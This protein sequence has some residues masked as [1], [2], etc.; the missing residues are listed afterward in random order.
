LSALHDLADAIGILPAYHDVH[1]TLRHTSDETRALLLGALGYDVADEAAA[2]RSLEGLRAAERARVIE[3]VAVTPV[4]GDAA[5]A[6]DVRLPVATAGAVRWQLEVVEEAGAVHRA[7]GELSR[8]APWQLTL[9]L[10]ELPLGYHS[11]RLALQGAGADAAAE[12]TRIVVPPSCVRV[13]ELLGERG[14]FGLVANLYSVRREADWGVGDLRSL[15]MLLD[16]AA[17]VGGSFVGVNPLH[18]LRNRD[19]DVSPYSPVSRLFRNPLYIDVPSVPEWATTPSARATLDLPQHQALLEELREADRIDYARAWSLKRTALERLHRAFVSEADEARRADYEAWCAPREPALGDF[20]TFSA[21]QDERLTDPDWRTWP[22]E[23]RDPRSDAVRRW[24]DEHAR[25]VDFHRWLQWVLDA[26]MREAQA[27]GRARGLAIG[28]YQDLAI[29]TNPAGSDAWSF[30]HLF[31]P[32]VNVGAPPDPYSDTGQDWGLPPIDP[33]RLREGRYDYWVRLLRSAFENAGALRIDHV[34]GLFRLFWIPWG[35]SGREGAYVRYPAEDL[36]GILALESRRHGAVVVGE[37]LGTVPA[38]VPPALERWG[39]LSS[40]VMM[41]M[42][43]DGGSFLPAHRYP[44]RALATATTHDMAPLGGFWSGTDIGLRVELGLSPAEDEPRLRDERVRERE[45]L[46]HRL[47]EEGVDEVSGES[48]AEGGVALRAAVHAFV[49]RTPAALVGFS[50]DDLAG[51]EAPVNVPGVPPDRF[52][53]W[54]KRMRMTV[55]A[56][57]ESGAVE[58]CVRPEGRTLPA[59]SFEL[60]AR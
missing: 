44:R 21:L 58:A 50:L 53:S 5:R 41:F 46:L 45:T 17:D 36:L 31:V 27:H 3:P 40:S 33:R 9:Q 49:S 48:P 55:E 52:P 59:E 51:E 23:L 29:G 2:R 35:Y 26:Q 15:A 57:R 37:D 25:E 20:A 4:G 18:A 11:V 1:G 16:W 54:T 28:L 47:R 60:P 22:L 7:E 43:G 10:P 34:I 13:E 32:G 39:I 19:S 12:Q 14:A 42:R 8:G 6:L 24:R 30:G 56:M 38:E